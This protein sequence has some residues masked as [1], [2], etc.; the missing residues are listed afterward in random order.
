MKMMTNQT[1]HYLRTLFDLGSI[2]RAADALGIS[3]P[4]LTQ[5]IQRI[6]NEW[7][8]EIIDRSIRPFRPTEEGL[9]I[10]KTEQA[11]AE[12]RNNCHQALIDFAQGVRGHIRIGVSEYR[13]IFFLT[14]VLP[15]FKKRYPLVEISLIEGTTDQLETFA[16]DGL[17]DISITIAPTYLDNFLVDELF[18]EK[19]LL[20]VPSNSQILKGFKPKKNAD[21]LSL[22]PFE[23]LDNQPFLIVKSGQRLH[24]VFLELCKTT[25]AKPKVVLESESLA[26]SLALANAGLGA[27]I[28]TDH[29]AERFDNANCH[30]RYFELTPAIAPRSVIAIRRRSRYV[31]KAVAALIDTMKEVAANRKSSRR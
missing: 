30:L 17:T 11:V 6:E 5:Y 18:L 7:K 21:G 4:S 24:D 14:D 9:M 19:H 2:S 22:F 25:S 26:A 23:R 3:Q 15:I 20:A 10:L 1:A 27:T 12:L 13:E 31:P 29:L 16:R 28:V 8:V